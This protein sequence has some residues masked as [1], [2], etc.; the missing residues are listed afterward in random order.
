MRNNI[1]LKLKSAQE[2]NDPKPPVLYLLRAESCDHV[3]RAH[4][5]KPKHKGCSS[6]RTPTS[7][8]QETL[9]AKGSQP[10]NEPLCFVN[11]EW[12][13]FKDSKWQSSLSSEAPKSSNPKS[14]TTKQQKKDFSCR[15]SSSTRFERATS[16]VGSIPSCSLITLQPLRCCTCTWCFLFRPH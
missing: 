10:S 7:I 16:H 1:P 15:S 6:A 9:P 5:F 14:R 11:W 12:T 13:H 2:P 8:W 4:F 3:P